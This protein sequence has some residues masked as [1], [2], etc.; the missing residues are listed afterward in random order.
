MRTRLF[1]LAALAAAGCAAHH[2]AATADFRVE[3]PKPVIFTQAP[4]GPHLF[5]RAGCSYTPPP[6]IGR[7]K[8]DELLGEIAKDPVGTDS[9]ALDTLLFYDEETRARIA[10]P[11]G[12][13]ISSEWQAFL[14]HELGKR[15]VYMNLRVL[16]EKGQVR[17]QVADLLMALRVKRHVDTTD[18]VGVQP[19]DANG[20]AVRVGLKHIW[21]RM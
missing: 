10:D 16:D 1:A 6:G 9:L 17:A 15:N 19:M 13:P 18:N 3:V 20:T 4:P 21:F 11:T 14:F 7:A 12:L 5:C 8:V 2:P